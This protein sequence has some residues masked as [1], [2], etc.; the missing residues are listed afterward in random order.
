[1]PDCNCNREEEIVTTIN[2]VTEIIRVK[3]KVIYYCD[4]AKCPQ[5]KN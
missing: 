2:G 4:K 1:M 5:R 3:A